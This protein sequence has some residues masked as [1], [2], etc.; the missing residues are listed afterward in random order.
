MAY[1][2]LGNKARL[3][4]WIADVVG[5][6]LPPGSTIADPMCGTATMSV[7]FAS[8]GLCVVAG[9]ELTFP[10][11]HARARLLYDETY[12]FTPHA[13]S[14]RAAIRILNSLQ[15][16]KGFFWRE[17]GSKGC[18]R[19]RNAPRLYFTADNAGRIDSIRATIKKWRSEGLAPLAADLLLHDL[20][21]AVNRVANIAGTYGYFRAWWDKTSLS[22]LWLTPSTPRR[23]PG[24]HTVIQGKVEDTAK[25]IDAD[26]FYL[27]PPY[28]KRQ[29]GG[30]YHILETIA[31]EDEPEP[32]GDGGLR[33]WY[34]QASNFCYRRRAPEAFVQTLTRVK[35]GWV[36]VSYSEDG[37]ISSGDLCQLL[38]SF[39]SVH[40]LTYPVER[41]R[42][43]SR[44]SKVG[45]VHEHLYVVEM[46]NA[47]R[48]RDKRNLVLAT[49]RQRSVQHRA[50]A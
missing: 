26:A 38:S 23:F 31:R 41:F 35:A 27:D 32:I 14:Y 9:D 36:F 2:Y 43:N 39:G 25:W 15:P 45:A 28:T 6:T 40:R 10:V 19:N 50:I 44:V 7:A 18:P 37:H 47:Q 12:D 16:T 8:R 49:E 4:D 1:R 3:A 21:L 24:G 30:N 11:L 17:Y 48:N 22:R 42:S 20:L 13:E 46:T 5:A 34:P 33:D 29:Y